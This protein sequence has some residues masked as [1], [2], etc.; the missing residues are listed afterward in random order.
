LLG[1]EDFRRGSISKKVKLAGNT[2]L[3]IV[4]QGNLTACPSKCFLIVAVKNSKKRLTALNF[5]APANIYS[6][7][8]PGAQAGLGSSQDIL[9]GALGAA[10]RGSAE[11]GWVM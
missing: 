7:F 5:Y 2:G 11:Q 8:E 4:Y 1:V 3:S 10:Q 9:S 6:D